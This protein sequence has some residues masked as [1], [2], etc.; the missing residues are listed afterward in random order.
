MTRNSP[1]LSPRSASRGGSSP[2]PRIV[3]E[4]D[5]LI[6]DLTSARVSAETSYKHHMDERT[7]TLEHT[8]TRTGSTPIPSSSDDTPMQQLR[9]DSVQVNNMVNRLESSLSSNS[10]SG[11][12]DAAL[13]RGRHIKDLVEEEILVNEEPLRQPREQHVDR[14]IVVRASESEHHAQTYSSTDETK[15]ISTSTISTTRTKRNVAF[16]EREDDAESYDN[17]GNDEHRV[18]VTV[19]PR[20]STAVSTAAPASPSIQG[21]SKPKPDD[22]SEVVDDVTILC[23]TC[24]GPIEGQV[25]TALGRSYHREHFVCAHCGQELGT[26]NFFERD[27]LPYC[28]KDYHALFSPKCAACG[29]SIVERVTIALDK[30]YHPE[31]FVCAHCGCQFDSEHDEGFHERDGKPYCKTDFF[32]LFANKCHACALPITANYITALDVQWHPDCFICTDCR[33]PFA[34]GKFFDIDGAPYCEI[35]YHARRGSLCA[36]C[37]QPIIGRCITAM[38]RKFHPDHFTCT[39]CLKVLNKTFKEEADRPY[40]H[41]CFDKLFS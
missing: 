3:N 14:K 11:N 19:G 23:H 32:A 12:I 35:H 30:T 36:V 27:M 16:G 18:T 20:T 5:S 41:D 13:A 22:S 21:S 7:R 2:D 6:D 38:F 28:E 17:A 31:H 10:T 1:S 15:P 29:E 37:R 26:R 33:C 40:C 39:Y 25:I 34:D 4:L 24:N 9:R 8:I